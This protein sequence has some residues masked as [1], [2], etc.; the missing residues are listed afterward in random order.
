MI[1]IQYRGRKDR[2]TK[3]ATIFKDY[4]SGNVLDVGCDARYLAN[5]VLGPYTGVDIAGNPDAYVD[6]ECPLPYP[7]NGF[8][9]VVCMD[10][11]EHVD[12]LHAAFD[13]LCRVSRRYL[14]IGLP[15]ELEWWLRFQMVI[16]GRF[17]GNYRLTAEPPTDRHRWAFNLKEARDFLK[18]RGALNGFDV[19]NEAYAFRGWRRW[20]A[21]MISTLG[22]QLAPL[23]ANLL[24][25]A[26]WAVLSNENHGPRKSLAA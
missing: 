16:L 4:L 25:K 18:R 26:Y 3:M 7:D 21:R 5:L 15:N 13:E 10:V 9:T 22:C 2:L 12:H 17:S 14:I 1:A 24:A 8:D 23:G 20:P 6:L 11:L 19:V